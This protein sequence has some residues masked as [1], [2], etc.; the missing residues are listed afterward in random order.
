MRSLVR[1]FVCLIVVAFAV[2]RAVSGEERLCDPS[3]ENCRTPLLNLIRTETVGIDV[4]FWFMEDTRYASALI[5]RW[6]AGVPIRVLV[7]TEANASY[8]RN[9]DAL[10]MLRDAGIPMRE[11]SGGRGILHWKTMIFAG[12]DVVE[13]SAA[14][15]SDEA[16]VPRVPYENYVDEMI[17][18][19]DDPAY[20][21][22]FKTRYDDAWTNTAE[23]SNYANI[24]TALVRNYPTAPV[25]ADLNFVPWQNF[26]TRSV[27]RYRAETRQIDAI[28]YRITDRRHSDE[29]IAA[30]ARGVPVRVL[31]EP[32]QYRDP[33]RLWHAWNIDRMYA[34][35]VQLRHRR[36]AG[37]THQKLTILHGQALT[38]FGSSNWSS[39]SADAQHEH[40]LFTAKP[41]FF[42]WARS[43]FERKWNNS[44]GFAETQP[45]VPLPPDAAAVRHPV[46]G[47][48]NQPLTVSLGWNAG[49]WA[50]R[51]DV[52][53]GT[54]PTALTKILEDRELGPSTTAATTI[55]WT[56]SGLE[57]G[58]TYY[59]RVVSR[60]MAN[61]ERVGPIW[62][63]RTEG[64]PPAAGAS[65]VVLWTQRTTTR[66]G[67]SL[68]SDTSAAGGKLLANT[69]LNAAKQDP[70]PTPAQYFEL[71][72]TA[73]PGVPYRLWVRG[74]AAGN[75]YNNDSV[76]VQFS[77]SVTAAGTPVWRIGTASATNVTIEDCSG[78][79]LSA[80]GWN[81]N[82]Y[83][84]GVLG[85]AVYFEGSDPHV[86]RVQ[87][88]EDGLAIDQIILSSEAFLTSAPGVTKNDGM[89]YAEQN[90]VA[91]PP[92]ATPTSTLP[93]GW[94]NQDIGAPGAPGSANFSGGTFTLA[95]SGTDIWGSADRFHF[96]YT[97]LTGDG[98][99][100]ARI[101]ALDASDVWTKTGVM[102]RESLGANAKHASMFVSG[103]KGLAFQRRVS[104]GGTSTHTAGAMSGAPYWVRLV[105]SGSTFA[106]YASP[107]GSSWTLVG[108]ESIAMPQTIY[109]GLPIVS[110]VDGTLSRASV[111][112]VA[113]TAIATPSEPT[114]LLP[115]GWTTLDVGPVAALGDAKYDSGT[116][117]VQGSGADIWGTA[118]EFRYVYRA[119]TGDGEISAR[120]ASV[121]GTNA[122]S[123]AGVMIRETLQAGSPHALMLVSYGKGTAFQ[124]RV[125]TAGLSTHTAGPAAAAP[126]WVRLVRA[127]ATFT[128]FASEDGVAWTQV[129]EDVIT[130]ADRV[131]VGLAVT[132][133]VDGTVATDT[134]DNVSVRD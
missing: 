79:G 114:P 85:P 44:A 67:W 130:M 89:I 34:A 25:H 110:R 98:E 7:D 81:D 63:F 26:A 106:A 21:Q 91:L 39:P 92:P 30:V 76:W 69:N 96:A 88:R 127:G 3:F 57:P 68:L 72:F 18:F 47:A 2:P 12:Q 1:A 29:L 128:A 4:A 71:A 13:F 24:S 54:T 75:S 105:R 27:A 66:P 22:S 82:G 38:I 87:V 100:V 62:S 53:V 52:Y 37:L 5:E 65:D 19:T 125:T 134:F 28:M 51:Y 15:Y 86:I 109:V 40:N 73:Q 60:T 112:N 35:G 99:I 36:H 80:W 122:W 117:T 129:G 6:S 9:V 94:N 78:C 90:G 42:E 8:P 121:Q 14:N 113:V 61:V 31:T 103:G 97:T 55:A 58:T 120:V 102:M 118:D 124:R 131:Y 46:D 50:H 48:Q 11:K 43:N 64:A 32:E 108:T 111:T 20:V 93:A 45:F 84:A 119:L 16:F 41:A 126:Y 77:D 95:G 83:G 33:E 74:K 115:D 23:F 10:R 59:W 104:T 70:Q 49:P 56:V 133:K 101:A 116:W 132:S 123:K 107:T 17:V